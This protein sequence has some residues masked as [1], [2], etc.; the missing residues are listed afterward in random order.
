MF[1][2]GK[3]IL[4][5]I[6]G[7][8]AVYR[9]AELMR[10]LI[11]Q[12]AQVRCVMTQSA[13]KFVT[14]LTFEALSGE[15]VH[16]DLFDLTE[17]H[18]MGHIQLV[19][20]ADMVVVVPTTANLLAKICHGIA[21]DL[22]TTMLMVCEKPMLLA[23][24]MNV[25][26]WQA[27]TTQNN[28]AKLRADGVLVME[29]SAGEL[30]CGEQG[31][32]RLPEPELIVQ[33]IQSLF[34]EKKLKGQRWVINAGPT[35]EAWDAVRILTNRATGSLGT[36][37]A[38]LA[39]MYGAEVTLVAGP[40]T[41]LCAA[42]VTRFDIESAAEMLAACQEAA[43]HAD[44]FIGTAAVSDFHFGVSQKGKLKR[45][46]MQQIQVE[47]V[48]NTDIIAD[49]AKMKSRPKKVIGFAAE[50][51]NHI[52]FAQQKLTQKGVDAI[53]ANDVSNMGNNLASGWWVSKAGNLKIDEQD[54]EA[55][56]DTLIQ[57]IL[58][59]EHKS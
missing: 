48:T 25:S 32:G 30:A 12:G 41:P 21:D 50:S 33:T 9:A 4:L 5:G 19:R 15:K 59:L 42:Q 35:V 10:L 56:A 40:G 37:L 34:C 49:I 44:V 8:I 53:V 22:L 55:F 6:G 26:M 51:E 20:W 13:Q 29:P 11:K 24:A 54:K 57:H 14:P 18:G 46:D 39:T 36:K 58:D 31:A 1:F 23:P 2:Q 16:H 28:V 17:D 47:L 38:N 7:G 45:K 3:R 43:Q 52:A 27:K